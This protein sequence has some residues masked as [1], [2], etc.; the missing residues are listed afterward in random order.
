M[1]DERTKATERLHLL[2][3]QPPLPPRVRGNV[4]SGE[5]LQLVRKRIL[6]N[7]PH[8]VGDSIAA[9]LVR[10]TQ[11]DKSTLCACSAP[12]QRAQASPSHGWLPMS[13]PK[14][15]RRCCTCLSCG[16]LPLAVAANRGL[17][18]QVRAW[19]WCAESA[20]RVRCGKNPKRTRGRV[21][22]PDSGIKVT[23]N[24]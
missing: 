1:R 7:L 2:V 22:M 19:P 13:G 8:L 16:P 3:K 14:M 18:G 12:L 24:G 10:F 5:G 20:L 17:A 6:R 4:E 23:L 11:R 21:I 15:A 9:H